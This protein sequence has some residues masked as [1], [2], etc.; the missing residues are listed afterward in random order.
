MVIN[1]TNAQVNSGTATVGGTGTAATV[2]SAQ[3]T[4]I[5]TKG[6]PIGTTGTKTNVSVMEA[7]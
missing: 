5:G 4:T 3:G 6:S 2:S 1:A 7:G